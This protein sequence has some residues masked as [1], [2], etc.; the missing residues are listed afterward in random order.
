MLL[1][2]FHLLKSKD[3]QARRALTALQLTRILLV[4]RNSTALALLNLESRAR[5]PKEA[6]PRV[7]SLMTRIHHPRTPRE[8]A[9]SSS[10]ST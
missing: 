4:M 10:D 1:K 9:E 3:L 5:V 6:R 8:A 2:K 7:K